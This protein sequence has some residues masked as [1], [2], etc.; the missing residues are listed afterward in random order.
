VESPSAVGALSTVAAVPE[1]HLVV[2]RVLHHM[3]GWAVVSAVWDIELVGGARTEIP[4]EADRDVAESLAADKY[5]AGAAVI[6]QSHSGTEEPH[7]HVCH[8]SRNLRRGTEWGRG[9]GRRCSPARWA[10]PG[11]SYHRRSIAISVHFPLESEEYLSEVL[12]SG[13]RLRRPGHRVRGLFV[14]NVEMPAESLNSIQCLRDG[15]SYFTRHIP[16]PH[17][18]VG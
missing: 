7:S 18:F 5:E 1:T 9:T 12:P 16:A 2:D 4:A 14:G 10:G 17:H 8:Y 6:L 11:V 13:V 3:L 15:S